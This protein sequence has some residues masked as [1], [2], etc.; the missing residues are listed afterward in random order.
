MMFVHGDG[1]KPPLPEMAG[2]LASR[3]DGSSIASMHTGQRAAQTVRIGRHEDQ[4]HVVWHQAP[5]PHLDPRRFA[6]RREQIA[7]ERIVAL[8]EE[9]ARPAIA[10]LGDMVGM[11]GNDD[12][13]KTGHTP[14]WAEIRVMSI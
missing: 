4:M 14:T 9:R 12:A 6:I 5:S 3:L 10:A 1:A 13:S 7:I 8:L 2:A 11:T